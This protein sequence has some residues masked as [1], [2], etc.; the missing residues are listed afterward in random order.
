MNIL[1]DEFKVTPVV[2]IERM[3][4]GKGKHHLVTTHNLYENSEKLEKVV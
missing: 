3:P 2:V 1:A 4:S